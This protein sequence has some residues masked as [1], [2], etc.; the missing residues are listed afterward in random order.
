MIGAT[1][2]GIVQKEKKAT[3]K[4]KKERKYAMK[5]CKKFN[6]PKNV[7]KSEIKGKLRT[8]QEKI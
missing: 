6:S 8:N 7:K 1:R 2:G 4:M 5:N 3:R